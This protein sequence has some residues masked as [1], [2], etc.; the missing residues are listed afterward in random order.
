MNESTF[1]LVF[2]YTLFQCLLRNQ[3]KDSVFF[4]YIQTFA[5]ADVDWYAFS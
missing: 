2:N 5:I 3:L 1:S 4:S